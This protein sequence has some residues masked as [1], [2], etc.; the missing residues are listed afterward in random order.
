MPVISGKNDRIKVYIPDKRATAETIQLFERNM[1]RL[2]KL[3][4]CPFHRL[5]MGQD[6]VLFMVPVEKST[7]FQLFIESGTI[8]RCEV[9]RK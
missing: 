5:G 4:G 3:T 6:E 9:V 8:Y 2:W 7:M 1:E